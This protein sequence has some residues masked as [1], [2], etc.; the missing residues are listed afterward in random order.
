MKAM[1]LHRLCQLTEGVL[2]LRMSDFPQPVPGDND[3]LV[4]VSACAVCHTDLDEIEGRAP[5]PRLPIVLGHQIVG[6]VVSRGSKTSRF[7][8]GERVG[9]AWIFSACGK[10]KFC[11]E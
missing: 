4:R 11:L 7:S 6:T 2:P 3:L 8:I 9:I 5:P 10:C 1:V